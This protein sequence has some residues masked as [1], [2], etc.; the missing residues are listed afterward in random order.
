MIDSSIYRFTL[1]MR[2]GCILSPVLFNGFLFVDEVT[3]F[4]IC[5]MLTNVRYLNLK[6]STGKLED[7]FAKWD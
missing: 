6:I 3:D 2:Q 4:T 7:A 1:K 5:D